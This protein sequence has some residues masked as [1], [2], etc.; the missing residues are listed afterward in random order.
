MRKFGVL[1]A[2]AIAVIMFSGALSRP[3]QDGPY[4]SSQDRKKSAAPAAS[5]T[6][7]ADEAGRKLYIAR[8]GPGARI[9]VYNLDTL[10]SVGEIPN[11]SAHGA[12]VSSKSNHGFGSSKPVAMWDSKDA[13]A[14]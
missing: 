13:R 1:F 4:K 8:S 7:Y 3:P 12:A 5:T 11:T 6:F 10:D 2:V 14:D 9:A